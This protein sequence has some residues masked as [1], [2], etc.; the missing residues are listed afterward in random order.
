[1]RY[2][3]LFSFLLTFLWSGQVFAN[4]L[5]NESSPYLQQHAHN[6]V[7]WYPWGKEAFDRAKK[8]HKPIFL[9]IGYSTCHWCHVMEE[10]S[11]ENAEVAALLNRD[12][13][14][15]KVDKEQYPQIDK[16]YQQLFRVLEGRSGGWPLSVFLTPDRKPFHITTY[17][18]REAGYGSD[19][20]LTLLPHYAKLFRENPEKIVKLA[21][22]YDEAEKRAFSR[23]QQRV[24][25]DRKRID[26]IVKEIETEYDSRNGGFGSRPKF[27]EASKIA[28]LLDIYRIDGSQK[29]LEM[30]KETLTRMARSGIYDQIDGGFFRYTTDRG[31]QIPHF[32]K[33]LYTNAELIPLYVR[34]YQIDPKPLYL[35]VVR[36]T[37]GEMDRH[38]QQN[39]LYFSASDADSDGEEGGYFLYAYHNVREGLEKLGLSDKEIKIALEYL[40]I[41]EDGNIDGELSHSHLADRGEPDRV[42]DVKSYL[43]ELRQTRT[44]PFV[45]RKIITA[46]N[47]MMIKALFCAGRIDDRY[48]EEARARMKALIDKMSRGDLLYHQALL[49]KVPKQAGLLEDYA[50]VTDALI[51]AYQETYD[52]TYL[53]LAERFAK[54]AISLF[55]RQGKWYLSSDGI[56]T[57]ADSDDKHYTAPLSMMLSGLE[58]LAVLGENLEM[59]GIVSQTLQSYGKTL[60]TQPASAPKLTAVLLCQKIGT[61]LLKSNHQHLVAEQKRIAAIDYPFF[62]KKVQKGSG[63]M[64]CRIGTCFAEDDRLEPVIRKIEVERGGIGAKREKRWR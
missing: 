43:R 16:K 26:Q 20:L 27:P 1:L 35:K 11:F 62:L 32:E 38:Y 41:E 9:S 25:F 59:N 19:G 34:L 13:V 49:G 2:L 36:E 14:S 56:G 24:R 31:W 54:R 44:F 3:F 30:A 51:V 37:I 10:E 55:Y 58:R 28:L 29:V 47:A 42:E 33:M 18:P 61:I 52:D 17:I 6:P 63:Y 53:R 46:W 23:Q 48:K 45:D 22:A 60:N 40:G 50:F 57:E 21:A 4:A 15:I 64:A 39:G 12:Y 5:I 8:E 7:N